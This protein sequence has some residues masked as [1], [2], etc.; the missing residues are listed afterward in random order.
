MQ[1]FDYT[2]DAVNWAD[3]VMAAGGDGTF[4]LAASRIHQRDKPVI[5]I[6]TDPQG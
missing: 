6:N 2:E 3:A 5:G 1:R 4:L